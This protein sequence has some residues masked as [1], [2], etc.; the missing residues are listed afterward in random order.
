MS[1]NYSVISG[2]RYVLGE[3]KS[4]YNEALG[5]GKHNMPD[6]PDLW[7]WGDFYETKKEIVSLMIDTAKE[8][9]K[10]SGISVQDI[11]CV[12]LCSS[13][14]PNHFQSHLGYCRDILQ[15]L[16]IE[17]SVCFGQTLNGCG[18]LLSAISQA[19][20]FIK[21]RE[22]ENILIVSADK[23]P[24]G[25]MRLHS[26]ALFSDGAA[27]CLVSKP[28]GI[29]LKGNDNKYSIQSTSN[30]QATE[31]I[32]ENAPYNVDIIRDSN[33]ALLTQVGLSVEDIK[34]LC[35]NNL[36]LPV[37]SMKEE[38]GGLDESL[39]FQRNILEKGHCFAADV[40]INLYDACEVGALRPNDVALLAADY[41][42]GRTGLLIKA[43]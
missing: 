1:E 2:V 30:V 11:D 19:N 17:N 35:T 16:G 41:P 8:T 29:D 23:V 40:L 14:F 31:F 7:G 38:E 10:E 28:R 34:L 18:A 3:K 9:I 22:Y 27:S 25:D 21:A 37:V 24:E 12:I 15:S 20:I 6:I 5:Y 43:L 32:D 39:L 36:Y 13:S 4:R 26:Y 42:G 33:D